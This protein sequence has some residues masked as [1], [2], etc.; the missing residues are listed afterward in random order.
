[1]DNVPQPKSDNAFTKKCRL[2]QSTYRAKILKEQNYGPG[3][4][5]NS[6][7]KYENYLINGEKRGKNFLDDY[8]FRYAKSK[9]LEKQVN[10]DLTIDEYRL[11]NNMLSSMPMAFNLFGLIRKFLENGNQE[12]TQ[13]IK[14]VFP[15]FTWI[16]QVV[17]LDVE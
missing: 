8:I 14:S 6:N 3:P 5:K 10:P 2:L 12:A 1:M 11:F 16:E 9:A 4:Y 13:I 15:R 7:S 17:Y